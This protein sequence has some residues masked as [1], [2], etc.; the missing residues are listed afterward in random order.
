VSVEHRQLFQR[1]T[2]SPPESVTRSDDRGPSNRARE[3]HA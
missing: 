1:E 2:D 3:A